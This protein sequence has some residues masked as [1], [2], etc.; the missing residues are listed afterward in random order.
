[1]SIDNDQ[2]DQ[3]PPGVREL[4]QVADAM[5]AGELTDEQARARIRTVLNAH[6]ELGKTFAEAMHEVARLKGAPWQVR[7][8]ESWL[9]GQDPWQG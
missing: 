2:L 4:R 7:N 1:M 5:E 8:W 3:L 9:A 6:P